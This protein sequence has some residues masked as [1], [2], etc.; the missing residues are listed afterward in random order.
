MRAITNG[1]V[2]GFPSPEEVR[3]FYVEHD[4]DGSEDTNGMIEGVFSANMARSIIGSTFEE[5][6]AIDIEQREIAASILY[7]GEIKEQHDACVSAAIVGA[8]IVREMPPKLD[9]V[10]RSI[11]NGVKV[12]WLADSLGT[13]CTKYDDMFCQFEENVDLQLH[14]ARSVAA[15]AASSAAPDAHARRLQTR[16]SRTWELFYVKTRIMR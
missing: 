1:Q 10:I 6:P 14:A 15:F 7:Y 16:S 5:P 2:E 12:G 9:P 3:T 8:L 13:A 4:M 11:V